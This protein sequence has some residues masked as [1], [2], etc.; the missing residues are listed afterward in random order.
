MSG[1]PTVA[2][3][4]VE[5]AKRSGRGS[6]AVRIVGA[7]KAQSV[8]AVV[9]ACRDGLRDVGHNYA[10]EARENVPLVN[11]RL[12]AAGEPVP[13]WHFIG[14]LQTNKVRAVIPWCGCIQSLDRTSLA[15][16]LNRRAAAAERVL[17]VLIQVNLDADPGKGGASPQE[18][19]PLL[20]ARASWPNLDIVGLMAIPAADG[21]G[22]DAR[23]PF[24]ALRELRDQHASADHPL[25]HLSMG[26]SG[27]F[28]TAI[29]EGATMVRIGTALFGPRRT[30]A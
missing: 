9:A 22:E 28:E 18:L 29:E 12:H 2:E 15:T 5:A 16:E 19:E 8:E 24:A 14:A 7:A 20:D 4:V 6:E 11:E 30:S 1:Y 26:M 25:P 27:D 23:R 13:A 17:E 10:Q 21:H 3:R